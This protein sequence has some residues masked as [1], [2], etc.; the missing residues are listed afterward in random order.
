MEKPKCKLT[1]TDGNAFAVIGKVSKTLKHA[2]QTEQAK[3]FAS[4]AFSCPSYDALLALCFE[5]VDVQ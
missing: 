1:G 5:F 2:G 3:D 4:K